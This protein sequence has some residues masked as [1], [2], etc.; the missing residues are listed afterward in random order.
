MVDT[1][2]RRTGSAMIA[3]DLRAVVALLVRRMRANPAFPPHQFGVLRTIERTGPQTA[4]QLAALELVRPQSMAHTLQQLDQ[5]GF[6]TRQAD[7][8]DRR[9]RLIGLS[10][11]G[12]DALAEQRREVTGWLAAAIEEH[13]DVEERAHLA[14]AVSLLSRLVEG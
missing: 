14:A 7:P 8:D 10:D 12:R 1:Q 6:I 3:E 13:L 2:A 5:A 4:S 9:Q 11:R